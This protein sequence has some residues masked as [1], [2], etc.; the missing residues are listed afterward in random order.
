ML[1]YFYIIHVIIYLFI[2]NINYACANIS[3]GQL[4]FYCI[5]GSLVCPFIKSY[6]ELKHHVRKRNNYL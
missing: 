3:C 1:L 2:T 6:I 4:N 5:V